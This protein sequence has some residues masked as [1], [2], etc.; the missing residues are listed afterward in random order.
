MDVAIKFKLKTDSSLRNVSS[1]HFQTAKKPDET[2]EVHFLSTVPL[3]LL[4]QYHT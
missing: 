2:P 3:V 4:C 1:Y